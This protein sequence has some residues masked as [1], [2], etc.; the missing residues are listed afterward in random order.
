MDVAKDL[1]TLIAVIDPIGTIPIYL[2]A[3]GLSE[4]ARRGVAVRA[5][6]ISS[7]S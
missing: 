5:I 7:G 2:T 4:A 3:T 6:L 1:I